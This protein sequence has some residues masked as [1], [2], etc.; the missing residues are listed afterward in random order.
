MPLA[1]SE[2]PGSAGLAAAAAGPEPEAVEEPPAATAEPATPT[3]GPADTSRRGFRTVDGE[4]EWR[5]DECEAWNPL[6]VSSCPVCGQPMT[7]TGDPGTWSGER[8][9]RTRRI[10]WVAAAVVC[11]L[12]LVAVVVGLVAARGAG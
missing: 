9:A 7:G 5:C 3:P 12:A 10:L 11:L 2:P 8:V 6:F 1:G 4:V